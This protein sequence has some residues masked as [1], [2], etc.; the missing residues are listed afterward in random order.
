MEV[1]AS[2]DVK[3]KF[4]RI[5]I[6]P[7]HCLGCGNC[8]SV[9]SPGALRTLTSKK[10]EEGIRESCFWNE[11]KEKE[12]NINPPDTIPG[13]VR[14]AG[15]NR[16]LLEF[17]GSC[18]GCAESAYLSL[19]T[20]IFGSSLMIANATGCSSIWGGSYPHIPYRCDHNGKAPTFC[21]SLFENNA[22]FGAGINESLKLKKDEETVTWIVGGDGWASDIDSDGIDYLLDQNADINILI[23]DNGSYANT[24]GQYSSLTPSGTKVSLRSMNTV[25]PKDLAFQYIIKDNVYLASVAIGADLNQTFRAMTEAAAHKGP[26]VVIAYCPCRLHGIKKS[27]STSYLEEQ[28]KAVR[29]GF[30]FLYRYNPV[31]V[32]KLS[33][34]SAGLDKELLREYLS[35]E[36][37]FD[38]D[39]IQKH[40]EEIF[41]DRVKALNRIRTYSFLT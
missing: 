35:S 26:S 13:N 41:N 29:S 34:D 4:F 16:P 7:D 9:C 21:S 27:M 19:L 8:G 23:L 28:K 14:E 33:L 24:G 40:F 36:K 39:Y 32:K 3:D 15:F 38:G 30:R 25:R 6:I 20:R 22:E 37:R 10:S 11:L 12:N 31:S 5:Q 2:K 1:L 18:A 17:P